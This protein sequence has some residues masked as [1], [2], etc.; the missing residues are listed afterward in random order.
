MT[1]EKHVAERYSICYNTN[2]G[3]TCNGRRLALAGGFAALLTLRKGVV[4]MN[5]LETVAII[6]LAFTALMIGFSIGKSAK[7]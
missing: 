4:P 1:H 7:K 5:I 6:S 3:T 2:E